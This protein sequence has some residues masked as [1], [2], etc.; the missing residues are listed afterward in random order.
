MYSHLTGIS[1][2]SMTF[3][4]LRSPMKYVDNKLPS[5]YECLGQCQASPGSQDIF[6]DW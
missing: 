4:T 1:R 5:F 3:D 6:T 2:S